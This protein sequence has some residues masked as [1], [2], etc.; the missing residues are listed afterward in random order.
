M[1]K[2]H[3]TTFVSLPKDAN[4]ADLRRLAAEKLGGSTG[5]KLESFHSTDDT[6][7]ATFSRTWESPDPVPERTK[8]PDDFGQRVTHTEESEEGE[9]R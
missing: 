8:Y 9:D 6:I 1:A 4:Q 3:G 7:C 5:L 2:Q